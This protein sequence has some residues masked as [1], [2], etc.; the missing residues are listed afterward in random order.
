LVLAFKS[1][2]VHIVV[3]MLVYEINGFADAHRDDGI[4]KR[5]AKLKRSAD[6]HDS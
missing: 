6:D 1:R 2:N 4:C 3:P 5:G